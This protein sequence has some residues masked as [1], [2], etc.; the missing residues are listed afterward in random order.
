M[1]EFTKDDIKILKRSLEDYNKIV[2]LVE[3]KKEDGFD[4]ERIYSYLYNKYDKLTINNLDKEEG[5]VDFSYKDIIF[6]LYRAA[7]GDV[8]IGDTI[9]VWNNKDLYCIGVF[10]NK[11]EIEKIIKDFEEKEDENG[12]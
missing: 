9:D 1:E 4:F 7:N 12:Q 6:S 5:F 3:K 11:E 10:N 8:F 2:E